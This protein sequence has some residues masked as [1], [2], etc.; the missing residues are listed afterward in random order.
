MSFLVG[1]PG[2]IILFGE[3]AVVY[4]KTAIAASLGLL[5]YACFLKTDENK[6]ILHLTDLNYKS[7]WSIAEFKSLLPLIKPESRKTTN[8][9]KAL[10]EKLKPLIHHEKDP[11]QR[12]VLAFLYLTLLL[13]DFSQGFQ[14]SVKSYLPVGSGLG[15][16]AS[17]SVCLA[18]GLRL[19]FSEFN[20]QRKFN[21]D[22]AVKAEERE[23]IN[24]WAFVAEKIMHGNP[25]G[26]DNTLCTFGGAKSYLKGQTKSI[27][28]F[29]SFRFLLTNTKV[30][31]DTRM[32]V[33][34][35]RQLWNSY[36]S[37]VNPLFE[38]V[39]AI[40]DTCI[41]L[42]EGHSKDPLEPA[43]LQKNFETLIEINH[44]ILS[45]VGVSHPKI[46]EVRRI[47]M[48]HGLHSKLTGAGGGGCVLT[49]IPSDFEQ[50]KLDHAVEALHAAGFECYDTSIGSPGVQALCIS[51][52]SAKAFFDR[53][54][55]LGDNPDA[56]LKEFVSKL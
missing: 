10:V 2:K 44:N 15:S 56:D 50:Q 49:L 7:E 41:G 13:S 16:S 1:A 46:E 28:G 33:D 24:H 40:S 30:P 20:S 48:D 54:D 19:L 5:T 3:H 25:S 32:Q 35:V 42:F 34:K 11:I 45:A 31:K 39:Q 14:V 52:K 51:A 38:S 47:A 26:I 53:A 6:I 36:P 37:V 8:I 27:P 23:L 21:E 29:I 9:D 12:A 43:V 22:V 4:G 17:Y 55:N 18:T